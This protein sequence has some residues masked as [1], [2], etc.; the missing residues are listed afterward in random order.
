MPRSTRA[1]TPSAGPPSTWRVDVEDALPGLGAGV[2]DQPEPVAQPLLL[3]HRPAAAKSSAS[4]AGLGRGELGDVRLVLF[5]TT[6][7]CVGACGSMSRNASVGVGLVDH[8]GRDRRRRRTCRTGSRRPCGHLAQPPAART[9]DSPRAACQPAEAGGRRPSVTRCDDA[10]GPPGRPDRRPRLGRRRGGGAAAT[11]THYRRLVRL[12]VLLVAR[13]GD[14]RGGRPGLLRRHARQVALAP[15]PRQGAGLPAADRG[16]PVPLRAP[17]P[18]R[19]G[20]VAPGA[21]GRP[22]RRATR[23]RRRGDAAGARRA[24]AAPD[25]QREVLALRYYLDLA[26]PTSPR[27]SA[28]AAAP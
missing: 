14:G 12:S 19:A 28:S 5:G 3:R 10:A 23:R 6:S 7:T 1:A 2:E 21:R 15:R 13:P 9:A 22:P 25:R 27:S 4:V 24:A 8:V 11:P 20:R 17:P 18:W 16:E 26:R